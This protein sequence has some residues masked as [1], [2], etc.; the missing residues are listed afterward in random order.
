MWKSIVLLTCIYTISGLSPAEDINRLS[1]QCPDA[2]L[3]L[4][5]VCR[6]ADWDPIPSVDCSDASDTELTSVFARIQPTQF[7][8]MNIYENIRIHALQDGVFGNAS[9][10][11]IYVMYSSLAILEENALR[12][13]ADSLKTVDFSGCLL[14]SIEPGKCASIL[15]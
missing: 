6:Q 7:Y 5:C 4:P 8:Q 13:S 10:E 1:T 14:E 3:L 15:P 11:I 2:D 9:F 12:G